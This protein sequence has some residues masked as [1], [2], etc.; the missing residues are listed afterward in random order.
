MKCKIQYFDSTDGKFKLRA[1]K[2]RSAIALG[3]DNNK[4][5]RHFNH[6]PHSF[7]LDF[8]MIAVEKVY[9]SLDT[10]RIRE[11]MYTDKYDLVENGMN[12]NRT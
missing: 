10:L 11:R 12:S 1:N 3:T 2:W 7:S 9:G 5:V 8:R 4:V 6:T